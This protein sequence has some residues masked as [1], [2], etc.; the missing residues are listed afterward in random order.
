MKELII[1]DKSGKI[2]GIHN[3]ADHHVVHKGI[4]GAKKL[5]EDIGIDI[6]KSKENRITL[7][8]DEELTKRDITDM[9]QHIGRHDDKAI[10]EILTEINDIIEAL[11]NNTISKEQAKNDLLKFIQKEKQ[12]LIG[13]TK[14][15]NKI[16]RY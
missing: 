9:T 13:G 7:P 12:K 4:P 10:R 8:A 2:T 16:G 3:C 5:F 1:T 6:D 14:S 15:L 11:E